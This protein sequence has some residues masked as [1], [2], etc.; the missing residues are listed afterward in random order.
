M[1]HAFGFPVVPDV[2]IRADR[3]AGVLFAAVRLEGEYCC[4]SAGVIRSDAVE[5]P[6]KE[7]MLND[8]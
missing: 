5:I 1:A 8:R 4:K 2:Y 7:E 3:S 6:S